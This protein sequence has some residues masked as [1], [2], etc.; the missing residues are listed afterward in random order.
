MGDRLEEYRAKRTAGQTPEPFGGR[1]SSRPRLFVVQKHAATSLHY[2][3]RLEWQ[4]V[5]LSWAVPKGPHPNPDKLRLAMQTEDH[6]VEYADFEG[7]IPA[8]NYGA[9]QVIVWDQG[10]WVPLEDFEEGLKKGKLLFELK[11][12]KL[13]GVWTLFRTKRDGKE[14]REWLLRKHKD[15][16]AREEPDWPETSI[17]SGLLVEELRDGSNKQ[18]E[19]L[20]DFDAPEGSV[21][22]KVMLA[23]TEEVLFSSKDWIY[24]LKYD[25]FRLLCSKDKLLYRSGRDA[26]RLY[27]EVMRA[28]TKLPYDSILVDCEICVLDAEGAPDFQRLQSRAQL[29]R[30]AEIEV[31]AV[32]QPVLCYVFDLL[33]FCGHDLRG[34]PLLERKRILKMALPEAGALRYADH[35]EERGK[36]FFEQV[37]QMGLEGI[38]AKRATSKYKPGRS[39]SWLK[40]RVDRTGDFVIV[41]WTAPKGSRAGLGALHLAALEGGELAYMGRVGTGFSDK[42]LGQLRERLE[43]VETSEALCTGAVPKTAGNYWVQPVLVC[44][45]RFKERTADGLL[46][47][48]AFLRM[49]EDKQPDECEAPEARAAEPPPDLAPAPPQEEERLFTVSNPTKVFWPEH[50][51]TKGDLIDFYRSVAP[52]MLP[53]MR[54]RPVVM[55]RYPDGIHGKS[56]YQ[57]DAPEWVPGWLRTERVWSEDTQREIDYFVCDDA[58]SLAFLANMGTI[59]MHIWSSRATDLA[60]PDWCILDLD[61]KGAPFTDVVKIALAIHRLCDKIEFPNY[62]KTS[63]STGLHILLPLQCQVTYEQSR[64]IGELIARVIEAELGDIST[65]AR[66]MRKREGKVYL[67]YGQNAHGQLLVAPFSVRPLPGAP[68]STPLRWSEVHSRLELGTYTIRTVPPRLEKL[69]DDPLAGVLEDKP[70]LVQILARLAELVE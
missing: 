52:T 28:M 7:T 13:K 67:D 63:G 8:G 33:E 32:E 46:R 21:E 69:K 59:P 29:S 49:R 43:T 41:G 36:E 50:G 10:S 40:L 68:V 17:F 55:T 2:D 42:L 30:A 38:V 18:E 24:E 26:T 51:Y 54:D 47:H 27:P 3:L 16:Y 20:A 23:Q 12:H 37:R 48:P 39:G 44:E 14:T 11:G 34:L 65:T 61:P 19:I 9:G 45:V 56:F 64:G 58:E 4:G 15:A 31:G 1:R 5:L 60:K 22:E 62:V 57:K 70:D 6:P 25:G 53:Y 66:A 35:I